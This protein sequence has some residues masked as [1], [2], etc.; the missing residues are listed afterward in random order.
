MKFDLTRQTFT[1]TLFF[2]ALVMFFYWGAIF[3]N[4]GNFKPI[5]ELSGTMPIGATLNNFARSY[6]K[7][8]SIITI[9]LQLFNALYI[10]RIF[11]RNVVYAKHTHV[12]AILFI[13]ISIS[14]PTTNQELVSQLVTT[15]SLFALEGI[16]SI[17]K[18]INSAH[19]FF[20]SSFFIAIA[21]LIYLPAAALYIC[22]LSA[23]FI[24]NRFYLR[25][26]LASIGG[27]VIPPFF[28]SYYYWVVDDAFLQLTHDVVTTIK[29]TFSIVSI[30]T[31]LEMNIFNVVFIVVI[32]IIML[33]SLVN[34]M[35]NLQSTRSKTLYSYLI[36]WV[37]MVV[38]MTIFI[39]FTPT[40]STIVPLYAVSASVILSF[41]FNM[42]TH[43]I[44]TNII[45]VVLVVLTI[46]A[47]IL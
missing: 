5:N 21:G 29:S 8:S 7:L 47:N 13:L 43:R 24:Y 16:L 19:N 36:F 28:Y 33:F 23:F 18:R 14:S 6:I 34:F 2:S 10:S 31:I 46:L 9:I 32:T 3:V 38:I 22:I 25:E 11:I 45:F 41:L 4:E 37:W 20:L 27:F 12:A 15:L 17:K 44:V 26:L 35:I 1:Q 39:L 42:F 40:I 30:D